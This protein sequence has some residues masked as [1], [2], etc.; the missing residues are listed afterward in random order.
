VRGRGSGLAAT[1]G[2]A[3]F[4]VALIAV[5]SVACGSP[6]TSSTGGAISTTAQADA[7]FSGVTLDGTEVSLSQ[8]RGKPLVLAFMASW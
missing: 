1:A 4:L 3:A 8:Y 7:G 5:L 6:A 2:M